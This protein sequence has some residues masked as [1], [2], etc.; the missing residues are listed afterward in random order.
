MAE[1]FASPENKFFEDLKVMHKEEPFPSV[2]AYTE[3][4]EERLNDAITY[5]ELDEDDDLIQ[6][7][8]VLVARWNELSA[9]ETDTESEE[10]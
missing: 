4:I 3:A 6:L 1:F 5:G 8:D 10:V 7:K 9:E 2:E